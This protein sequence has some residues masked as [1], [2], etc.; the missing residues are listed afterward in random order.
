MYET[1][2]QAA[3]Q[4]REQAYCPYSQFAVGAALLCRDGSIYTG[5]N[6][7]NGAYSLGICAERTA[8]CKAVSDGRRQFTAIAVCGGK[9]GTSPDAVTPPCG[10]CRQVMAEFCD[11]AFEIVLTDGVHTLGEL[12]P[13]RFAL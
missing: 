4:A 3:R 11:D 8:F 6:V 1:L 5:C 10:A 9:T 12:L 13:V 2:M 7:E